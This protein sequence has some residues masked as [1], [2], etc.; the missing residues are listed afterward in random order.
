MLPHDRK[1]LLASVGGDDGDGG[2][3]SQFDLLYFLE[4]TEV[5]MMTK[6][7]KKKMMMRPLKKLRIVNWRKRTSVDGQC[8]ARFARRSRIRKSCGYCTHRSST[9]SNSW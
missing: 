9:V 1:S 4:L 5:R 3:Q 7:K 6:R 8:L 2:I